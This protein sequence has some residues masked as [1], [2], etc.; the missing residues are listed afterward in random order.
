MEP[1]GLEMVKEGAVIELFVL[2]H[3]KFMRYLGIL[4]RREPLPE[5]S[6]LGFDPPKGRVKKVC[7]ALI[8]AALGAFIG[9]FVLHHGKFMRYLGSCSVGSPSPKPR[10]SASTLPRGGLKKFVMH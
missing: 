4:E 3:G 1:F 9:L 10:A 8:F 2:H 7:D 6:C 5:A